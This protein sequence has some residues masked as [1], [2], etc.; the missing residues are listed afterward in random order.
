MRGDER[1][2]S[3]ELGAQ[4][5][6]GRES[7]QPVRGVSAQLRGERVAFVAHA[8]TGGAHE[9][10]QR[11]ARLAAGLAQWTLAFRGL[12]A[13]VLQSRVAEE[14]ARLDSARREHCAHGRRRLSGR[15]PAGGHLL[16][17]SGAS[18]QRAGLRTAQPGVRSDQD[19]VYAAFF[20][21][22]L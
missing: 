3:D 21:L 6:D 18:T 19:V 12:L 22:N 8:A 11:H 14:P 17:V 13:R 4:P 20:Y 5:A 10:A 15:Q 2:R 1:L 9:R 16:H 7:E